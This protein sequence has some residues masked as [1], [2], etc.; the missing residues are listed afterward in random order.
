MK[1]IAALFIGLLIGGVGMH[2]L[3][4]AR[5]ATYV[6]GYIVNVEK[7][8]VMSV[9]DVID[10]YDQ[11]DDALAEAKVRLLNELWQDHYGDVEE[12]WG[13]YDDVVNLQADD[14]SA[15]P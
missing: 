1:T 2:L 9:Q 6:S 15:G 8:L 7:P 11:G 14:V 4:Y 10:T 13:I 12:T 5:H 3:C